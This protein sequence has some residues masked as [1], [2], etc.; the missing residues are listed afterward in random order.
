MG[1]GGGGGAPDTPA[2][3][4]VSFFR[5]VIAVSIIIKFEVSV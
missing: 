1:G 3:P 4:A 2:T 5:P